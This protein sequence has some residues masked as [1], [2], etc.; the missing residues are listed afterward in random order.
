M[1][2]TSGTVS[3]SR[4]RRFPDAAVIDLPP[5]EVLEAMSGSKAKRPRDDSWVPRSPS[6][7]PA[8]QGRGRTVGS[9]SAIPARQPSSRD[10][11]LASLS[12]GERAGVRGNRASSKP[13]RQI[14]A[15][16]VKLRASLTK[17]GRFKERM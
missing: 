15:G 2:L 3:H 11:L 12:S 8:P 16:A 13:A 5:R 6:P 4:E 17:T 10:E 7:R 9:A 1:I 14:T